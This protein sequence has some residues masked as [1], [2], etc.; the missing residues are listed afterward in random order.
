MKLYAAEKLLQDGLIY[1]QR[2]KENKIIPNTSEEEFSEEMRTLEIKQTYTY[3][4]NNN[5]VYGGNNSYYG[6]NNNWQGGG[7]GGF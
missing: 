2:D 4:G 6:G 5:N 7:G 3:S 1:F